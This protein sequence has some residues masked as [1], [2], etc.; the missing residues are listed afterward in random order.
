MR[1]LQG[2]GASGGPGGGGG[3]R[4]GGGVGRGSALRA[5]SD[6]ARGGAADSQASAREQAEMKQSIRLLEGM[7]KV[8]R[9]MLS[10]KDKI[11]GRGRLQAAAPAHADAAQAPGPPGT[12]VA[13]SVDPGVSGGEPG[14]GAGGGREVAS[15]PTKWKWVRVL[16]Q[17][18]S[19]KSFKLD[20]E[21]VGAGEDGDR[22]GG[23]RE[24][25]LEGR[26]IQHYLSLPVSQYNL[27]DESLISRVSEEEGDGSGDVF[28]FKLPLS[29]VNAQMSALPGA[30]PPPPRPPPRPRIDP[31]P[32][33][34]LP[35]L[36]LWQRLEAAPSGGESL[37]SLSR[38]YI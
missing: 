12:V 27:L 34:T 22:G 5:R 2:R 38:G 30:P 26:T 7:L 33:R 31:Y 15:N 8:L 13:A 6:A 28:V 17:G 14:Q 32:P 3:G 16:A 36:H 4:G 35:S 1:G 21:G 19:S 24:A 23:G 29:Q 11:R 37:R 20:L 10:V 9:G 18:R 25:V